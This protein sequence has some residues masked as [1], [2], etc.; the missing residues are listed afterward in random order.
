MA[1]KKKNGSLM[2]CEAY[3]DEL[4]VVRLWFAERRI[5]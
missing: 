1:P 4:T 2:G 3:G 5:G